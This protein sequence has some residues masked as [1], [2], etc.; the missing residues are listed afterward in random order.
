MAASIDEKRRRVQEAFDAAYR[1]AD[2][3][4]AGPLAMFEPA[5][6]TAVLGI[7][8]ALMAL[9]IVRCAA[10]PRPARYA[11]DGRAYEIVGTETGE[12]G[13]R[14]GKIAYEGPVGRLVG[15]QHQEDGGACGPS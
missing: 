7:G 2:E 14:F 4:E 9:W 8:R 3:G 12:V 10:R 6:W 13:T 1:L 11:H 15:E 5:L